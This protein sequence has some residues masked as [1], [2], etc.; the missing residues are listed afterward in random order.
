MSNVSQKINADFHSFNPK[1][2]VKILLYGNKKYKK[3][4][5]TYILNQTINYIKSS[6]R[7]EKAID[8]DQAI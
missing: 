2:I 4:V 8:D 5:N 6:K 3:D 1:T 7:F